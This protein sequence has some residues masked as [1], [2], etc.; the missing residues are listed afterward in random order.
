[1]DGFSVR[2]FAY[3]LAAVI[4]VLARPVM[5]YVQAVNAGQPVRI[6]ALMVG[7]FVVAAALCAAATVIPL[8]IGLRKMESFEF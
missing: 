1:M 6:D 4:V 8:R 7:A 2:R 5:A 3:A